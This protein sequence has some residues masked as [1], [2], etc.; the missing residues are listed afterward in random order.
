MSKRCA[1][2]VSVLLLIAA[3]GGDPDDVG[4]FVEVCDNGADDDSDG[5]IDCMDSDC[6]VVCD[7]H[8]SNEVDDDGDN[9]IDCMDND[10][11]G[12]CPEDCEDGVDNDGDGSTDCDDSDCAGGC[13]ELCADGVD[14]D[15]DGLID[16]DD[17]DCASTC[18]GDGDGALSEAFGGDDCDDNDP[19]NFPDNI[20][21]CDSVDNDCDALIDDADPDIVAEIAYYIDDDN[22]D[23]GNT[24]AQ[25]LR[26]EQPVGT[27]LQP[28]DCDDTNPD[29][30]P[31]APEVC[32]GV[33]DDCDGLFDSDDPQVDLSTERQWYADADGDGFGD[34]SDSRISC[35]QPASFVIDNTDC[36]PGDPM[37]YPGA[38]EI[39]DDGIDQDCV[40][41]DLTG[42][43]LDTA[44]TLVIDG[45]ADIDPILGTWAGTE[46]YVILGETTGQ[47]L[48]Q[49]S[50]DAL[51][52]DSSPA[53]IGLNPISVPCDDPD[54]FAC[55]FGFTVHKSDGVEVAGDCS[56]YTS[57]RITQLVD[58]PYGYGWHDSYSSGGLLL[59]PTF[60]YY[61]APGAFWVGLEQ[62]SSTPFTANHDPVAG[63]VDYDWTYA[64]GLPA[65]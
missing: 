9:L 29:I 22:D 7:E 5:D 55:D 1:T 26:C 18:D 59:G 57:Q 53:A 52:W 33:D 8:C 51:D 38:L 20:E 30:F 13:P 23:W 19:A 2:A 16:C 65:P 40:G 27:V 45:Q 58:G 49:W 64:Y 46:T 63:T 24:Y 6:F 37:S 61:Y 21:V 17:D 56:T 32:N 15:V 4:P 62:A 42:C 54:G 25:L 14:N 44:A 34:P 12:Q 35:S 31:M 41:G 36:S 43:N 48:C 50:W 60:M 3:C 28:G 39:C 11:I 10:C 47:L